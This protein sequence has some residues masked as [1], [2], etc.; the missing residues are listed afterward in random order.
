[1]RNDVGMTTSFDPRDILAAAFGDGAWEIS[2]ALDDSGQKKR[3]A[4][5]QGALSVGNALSV[6]AG[7]GTLAG[8]TATHAPK[9]TAKVVNSA[10]KAFR[11]K[12]VN[13]KA[14]APISAKKAGRAGA[15]LAIGA[16]AFN[17]IV[18]AGSTYYLARQG[19]QGVAKADQSEVHVPKPVRTTEKSFAMAPVVAATDEVGRLAGKAK[20]RVRSFSAD[21]PV[22]KADKKKRQVFGWASVTEIDGQPVVDR[23][24]DYVTIEEIEKAAHDY[25]Q[26]SRDGG[27]MHKRKGTA[28]L[29]ESL[30]VDDVKKDALGIP[31][32][33]PEGWWVGFQITDDDVWRMVEDG[34]RPMFSVHGSGKR[35]ET[36]I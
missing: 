1:M 16:A 6:P 17:P 15:A 7:I 31:K 27:D 28:V 34:E 33:S 24:N 11:L 32:D 25:I 35:V 14:V 9:T 8:V 12:P 3:D 22:S 29:I 10:K 30:I 2:K 21:I 26:N 20:K 4:I 5:A 18:D 13:N 19:K 23:Q 36:Y